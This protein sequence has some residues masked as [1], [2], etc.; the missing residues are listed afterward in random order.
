MRLTL[1]HFN[2]LHGRL[3]SLPRLA[4]LIQH[5]RAQARAEGR[6]LL[7]LDGNDSSDNGQW[8]SALTQGRANF[9]LL[10]AL[11]V[12]ATV[13]GNN[14]PQWGRAA[15][16]KLVAAVHFAVLAANL[17]D[18]ADPAR[19]AVPG[20]LAST[21]LNFDSFTLGLIGL[22][23]HFPGIYDSLGY[24]SLDPLPI[25]QCEI[26]AFK[27]QG[28]RALILLS[29]L[30]LPEDEALARACP[31]IAVI[32][33]GHTHTLLT[34]PQRIGETLIVQAGQYGQYLGRL[35]LDLDPHTGHATH[36]QYRLLPTDAVPPDPTLSATLE[37]IREESQRL[38]PLRD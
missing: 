4:A 24:Q 35:N 10:E 16:A 2:D 31:E 13:L 14:E 8:E 30:G 23:A 36:F 6:S 7:V 15:L 17:V 33:G 34:E 5:E 12:D 28:A 37:L 11:G 29:H 1:L 20:L 25:V 3:D 18:V 22:T 32:V 9:T 38:R 19:R 21:L 27:A 26:A